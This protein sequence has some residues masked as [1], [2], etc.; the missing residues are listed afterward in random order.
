MTNSCIIIIDN[1]IAK[2][3][4]GEYEMSHATTLYLSDNQRKSLGYD[5]I[6]YYRGGDGYPG[7]CFVKER[8]SFNGYGVL[9]ERVSYATPEEFLGILNTQRYSGG[10][11]RPAEE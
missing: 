9:R 11:W 4:C 10:M 3:G 6:T 8:T 7:A 1:I 5:C 2:S